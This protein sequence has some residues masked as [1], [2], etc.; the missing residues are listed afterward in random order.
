[1]NRFRVSGLLLVLPLPGGPA[2]QTVRCAE[3]PPNGSRSL[4]VCASCHEQARSQPATS[5]AHAL[6]TVRE[7]AALSARPVLTFKAGKYS[8][9]IET[10]ADQALYSVPTGPT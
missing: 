1:M 7:C 8:Y 4:P 6:E 10:R 5:M 9:R 3:T 2:G